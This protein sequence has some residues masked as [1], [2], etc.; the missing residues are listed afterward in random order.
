MTEE[1]L[2]KAVAL[3]E[4]IAMLVNVRDALQDADNLF[5]DLR[6]GGTMPIFKFLTPEEKGRVAELIKGFV[7]AKL[8]LYQKEY[9]LI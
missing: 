4:R 1:E 2:A 9:D 8:N 5:V 6:R 7:S 3:S